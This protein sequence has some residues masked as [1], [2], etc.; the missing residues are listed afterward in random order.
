[1]HNAPK[2]P[3]KWFSCAIIIIRCR[4]VKFIDAAKNIEQ[5]LVADAHF[6]LACHLKLVLALPNIKLDIDAIFLIIPNH[7]KKFNSNF[8][9]F[10]KSKYNLYKF[11]VCLA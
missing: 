2:T 1:M 10:S 4:I 7:Y 9:T 6:Y 3:N 11:D 5:V 8:N